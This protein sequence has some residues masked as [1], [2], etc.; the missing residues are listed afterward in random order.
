LRGF[1]FFRASGIFRKAQFNPMQR[2]D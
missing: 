2:H 1:D